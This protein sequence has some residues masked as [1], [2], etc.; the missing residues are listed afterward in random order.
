MIAGLLVGSVS[1]FSGCIAKSREDQP[2]RDLARAKDL[3]ITKAD[4]KTYNCY[5][6]AIM[7]Q[8]C[9]VPIGYQK[10]DS[11][12]KTF[13]AV[14]QDLG[15]GNVRRLDSNDDPINDD[16][17]KAALRCGEDDFHF[18]RLDEN[19]WFNKFSGAPGLY[20]ESDY[21]T[22][23]FW[24][25]KWEGGDSKRLI[26]DDPEIIFFAVKIGGTSDEE[27][28]MR[29]ENSVNS[30]VVSRSAFMFRQHT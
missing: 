29:F 6:N 15:P 24:Y 1:L 10:G 22:A 27:F 26:Y 11:T 14:V 7:K 13:E 23:S 19:G 12:S 25:P 2:R 28:S 30:Y 4:P 9:A 18:L 21:V 16:V 17:Y 3:D 8:I 5:G 20:V